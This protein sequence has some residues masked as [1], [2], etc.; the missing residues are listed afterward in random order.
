MGIKQR[1][2]QLFVNIFKKQVVKLVILNLDL[3]LTDYSANSEI[4]HQILDELHLK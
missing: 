4:N 3:V 1:Y 2:L